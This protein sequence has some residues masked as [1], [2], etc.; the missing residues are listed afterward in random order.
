MSIQ[1]NGVE[2]TAILRKA[3]EISPSAI[4]VTDASGL[5]EFVNPAFER[6]YGYAAG[7]V[8]GKNP[9]LLKSGR[10]GAAFYADL[11][12]TISSGRTWTGRMQNRRK[13]GSLNW[14]CSTIAPL[15]DEHGKIVR[16]IAVKENIQREE[17][18]EQAVA[19]LESRFRAAIEA[20]PVPMLGRAPNQDITFLNRAF[21]QA[22]G[23]QLEEISTVIDWRM[24]AFPDP[25]YRQQIVAAWTAEIELVKKTG[26]AFS[27]LEV[28]IRC[29]DGRVKTTLASAAPLTGSFD[30]EHV[31]V[32]F[33]ITERKRVEDALR[34]GEAKFR[35]YIEHS[36]IGVFI[37]DESGR[38]QEVNAAAARITGYTAAELLAM[39]I[40]DLLPPEARAAGEEHFQRLRQTGHAV[41]ENAFRRKDGSIGYWVVDAVRLSGSRCLGFVTETTERKSLESNLLKALESAESAN[42]AKSEFLAVMSHEL[43]TPLNGVLGFAELLSMTPLGEEQR[44]YT[45]TIKSSGAHLLQVVNDI[46]DFSSIEKGRMAMEE[47]SVLIFELLESACTASRKAA[48]NKGLAFHVETAAGVPPQIIGDARRIRQILI[49]LLGNAIKFTVRGGVGLRLEPG[50][51]SGLRFL[52]FS[53]DDTGPGIPPEVISRLFNPFTQG[54]STLRRPFQGT[55][56]GLAI[57]QRLARA[58]GGLITVRSTVGEGSRFVF[59]LPFKACGPDASE[60]AAPGGCQEF[61]KPSGESRPV[62]VVDDDDISSSLADKMLHALGYGAEFCKNGL[63]AV[64]VFAPGKFSAILMDMQMPVMDGI[65]ATKKIRAIEAVGRERTPIIA[66]TANVMPGHRESC[67]A[68]GMDDFLSKPFSRTELAAKLAAFPSR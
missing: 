40:P 45:Q 31:V 14:E 16:Y 65:A 2:E 41:G 15:C 22:F 27:P 19:H 47:K 8:L 59:R 3:W 26:A 43:R 4:V 30:E 42:R 34:A 7:E 67:L 13:D 11:W 54:D 37:T 25:G 39:G 38:Y 50:E 28:A 56:L 49:N 33:D 18:A 5:I 57:S 60:P 55:G 23:Y 66:L 62:L 46:L 24:K 68:A 29:R 10:H 35:S 21:V 12:K 52:D 17:Q 48:E 1:G 63:E 20:S 6:I 32:F 53:V 36:P 9:S 44:S 51:E 58:M 64:E 61:A